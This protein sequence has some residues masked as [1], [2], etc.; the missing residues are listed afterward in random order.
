VAGH[1]ERSEPQLIF[2]RSVT[3]IV[4]IKG[5]RKRLRP[6]CAI[7]TNKGLSLLGD[8]MSK[9][10]DIRHQESVALTRG[11]EHVCRKLVRFLIG[12]ISL[13]K[14]Q[15][16]VK[17]VYVEE[18]ENKLKKENP[19]KNIPLTQFALLSGLDTR[20]LTKIRND[21]TYQHPL[22][23]ESNFIDE[24]TPGASIL[25]IWCSTPPFVNER[26]GQPETL[27]ITGKKKSF[28]ALFETSTKSRGVTYKSL[29]KRLA[30][31]G[32][33]SIDQ[34]SD[35]VS[36]LLNQYLPSDTDDKLG[37]IE[38]GFSALGNMID[39]V[40][41]NINSIDTKNERLYQRGAWSYRISEKNKSKI[42]K[43]L[44]SVL[45]NADLKARKILAAHENAFPTSDQNTVGISLFY[46]E[47]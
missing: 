45:S 13:V 23:E 44:K 33:V 1:L 17:Y 14:L 43:E 40:T 9:T 2:T 31:S 15:Q 16:I 46:F 11:V 37:A 22:H 47:E 18:I 30:E 4:G 36:L 29:L 20:T 10:F 38:M 27:K 7:N 34:E 25:D 41:H 3:K 26:T 12:R 6:I 5:L 19:H 39:T 8:I 21:D 35:T 24:I 42:R 28:E 32:A